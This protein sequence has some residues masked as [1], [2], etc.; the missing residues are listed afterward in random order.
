MQLNES[1]HSFSNNTYTVLEQSSYKSVCI[2]K[3]AKNYVVQTS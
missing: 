3:G 2:I 1:L